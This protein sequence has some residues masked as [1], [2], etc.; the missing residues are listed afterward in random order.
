[1]LQGY[2]SHDATFLISIIG[3]LNTFGEVIVGWLGDQVINTGGPRYSRTFCLRSRLFTV[4]E[5]IPKFSIRSLFPSYSRFFKGIWLNNGVK[6]T[7]F[8]LTV[9][10]T[11]LRFQYSQYF[12]GAY[13]PRITRETCTIKASTT[14]Q[15]L[16]AHIQCQ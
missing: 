7:F 1:M 5:I 10:P 11:Y 2:S 14:C 4:Q 15:F 16:T 9:L 12:D 6:M 8:K 13:L 3:I